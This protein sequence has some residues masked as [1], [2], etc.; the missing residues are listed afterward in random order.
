MVATGA[1]GGEFPTTVLAV[2]GVPSS[3]PSFGVTT[4]ATVSPFTN[5]DGESDDPLTPAAT[6]PFTSHW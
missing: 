1:V 3:M 4:T 6:L 5:F 2:A